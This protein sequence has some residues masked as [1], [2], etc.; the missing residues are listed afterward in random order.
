[1]K[2]LQRFTNPEGKTVMVVERS[3][4]MFGLKTFTYVSQEEWIP[5]SW[6]WLS[7]PKRRRVHFTIEEQLN[8][9]NIKYMEEKK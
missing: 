6:T 1:M 9:W 7:M 5:G 8:K 4:F 2:Q 3:V